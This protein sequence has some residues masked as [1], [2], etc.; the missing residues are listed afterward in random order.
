MNFIRYSLPKEDYPSGVYDVSLGIIDKD[1]SL[2][3]TGNHTFFVVSRDEL[4][5]LAKQIAKIKEGKPYAEDAKFRNSFPALE[6]RL[7]WI[8]D[9]AQ[10]AQAYADI[11]GLKEWDEEMML[12]FQKVEMGEPAL[13][14]AGTLGRLAHRS[15]IDGTLQ[16]Y[17]L[18]V[19]GDYTGKEP[20][21]LYVALHGSGVDERQFAYSV[22]DRMAAA[23]GQGE[24]GPMI[25]LAP[26]ARDL[27]GWYLGNS[28]RDVLECI[29]H[30]KTLYRIDSKRIVLEGFSMGGYGA[31]RLSLLYPDMFKGAIIGSGA[32]KPPPPL[33][34]ENI[35]E[36][37]KPGIKVYYLVIHGDSDNAVPVT[38][39]RSAV[40]K[41]KQ[42]GIEHRYIEV[43]G[44]AHG[45]YDRWNEILSWLRTLLW[46]R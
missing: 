8:Q 39:A 31:W 18:F 44:G 46:S 25:I 23:M 16:P 33:A 9:F 38:N 13:F 41:L 45:N 29:E 2:R 14:P 42:L 11:S 37:M 28:G 17:S 43:K 32:I 6:I 35:I 3:H 20:I 26:K 10:N 30:V 15:Q 1:G 40:E 19:P 24:I 12:L 22:T 34:G 21:P 36:L 5:S 4:D 27:S 7:Q